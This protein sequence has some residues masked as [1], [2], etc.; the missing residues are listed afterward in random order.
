M[1]TILA[2]AAALSMMATFPAHAAGFL[3][4]TVDLTY[5]FPTL[6]SVFD[7]NG[8]K[9]VSPTATFSTIGPLTVKVTA[10][11][12]TVQPDTAPS[13]FVNDSFNGIVLTDLTKSKIS[14]VTVASSS[15]EPGFTSSD[16]TFTS[17]SVTVNFAGLSASTSHAFVLD[18][19]F[20]PEPASWA[21][22]I[23]GFAGLGAALR[24]G[25]PV[26]A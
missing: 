10:D 24:H 6:G 26:I 15:T 19:S 21:L 18:V 17:N 12:I 13:V 7:N 11:T 9:V 4:D 16:F 2:S 1:K 25:R 3:G 20:V 22:M 5:D 23:V 8:N 14:D